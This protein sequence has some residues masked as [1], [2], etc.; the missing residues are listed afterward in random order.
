MYYYNYTYV[1][2]SATFN[3]VEAKLTVLAIIMQKFSFNTKIQSLAIA[4]TDTTTY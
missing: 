4:G 3:I 2:I 1:R